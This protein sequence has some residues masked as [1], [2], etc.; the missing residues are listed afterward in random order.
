M[1]TAKDIQPT[2]AQ[3]ARRFELESMRLAL[4]VE[5]IRTNHRYT[6]RDTRNGREYN[7]LV[8]P[9]TFDFYEY[10]LNIGKQKFDMLIVEHHN[11]V[12]PVSVVSLSDITVYEPLA[13]PVQQRETAKRRNHDE[14][15]LLLAKLLLNFES[16][17]A[18]LAQMTARTRQRYEQ[19]VA[20]Y[21]T[22]KV[23]RPWAS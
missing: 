2:R 15:N 6:L 21:L 13:P 14:A 10:R 9:S 4:A 7:A 5:G 12:V 11:A 23:G 1:T 3:V 8:L 16:A 20:T 19:R 22:A 18:E 17:H